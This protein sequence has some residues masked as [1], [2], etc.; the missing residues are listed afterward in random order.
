[1]NWIDL[2]CNGGSKP[3]LQPKP[4]AVIGPKVLFCV[5][6]LRPDALLHVV[7]H[8]VRLHLTS[9]HLHLQRLPQARLADLQPNRE[10]DVFS[11]ALVPNERSLL[12]SDDLSDLS[13]IVFCV[14]QRKVPDQD[15]A[16]GSYIALP[17]TLLLLLAAYNHEKVPFSLSRSTRSR[18]VGLSQRLLLG[19]AGDPPPAAG[20]QSHPG[21]EDHGPS[22]QQQQRR[23]RAGGRQ[24]PGQE[25]ES[26]T[27]MNRSS[28]P[29]PEMSPRRLRLQPRRTADSLWVDAG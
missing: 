7:P 4:P 24:T 2:N 14:P 8:S 25:T 12:A 18:S 16:Q 23:R 11:T 19:S 5:P 10:A 27:Y 13:P 29:P 17:L 22:Q 26:Q 6:E 20:G 3:S 15:V 1:M 28:N 21:R 9:G